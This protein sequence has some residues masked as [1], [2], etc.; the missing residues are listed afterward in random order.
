MTSKILPISAFNDNYIWIIVQG[1]NAVVIDPGQSEPVLKVLQAKNLNLQAILVTHHHA[2]HV[3]GIAGLR[4]HTHAKVYGPATE[5]IPFCDIPLQEGD[6][7][8]IDGFSWFLSVLEVPGH[9]LGHIAYFG[10]LNPDEPVLF[11]GDTLFATGCGRIFEGTSTQMNQSIDK[12][13]KLPQNTLIFCAHEYTLGNIEWA[14][15]VEGDNP[16]LQ[17]WSQEARL[18]R[19]QQKPT[20]P[21]TVGHELKTNP[22]MRV[23]QASVIN[24]AQAKAGRS[25]S[26][27]DEVFA[28]LRDW[29]NSF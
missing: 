1:N 12:F 25:L 17:Q 11:C 5:I 26:A 28:V 19:G 8:A 6:T 20:V 2:D 16:D 14:L 18:I 13:R 3:G 9:T 23:D 7:V 10:Y 27:P 21:T 4:E 22:F 24:A 29:K 15:A